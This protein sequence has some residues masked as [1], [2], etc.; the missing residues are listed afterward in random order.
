VLLDAEF[1]AEAFA[2]AVAERPFGI[3]HIASHGEFTADVS[4]SFL[5]AWDQKLSMDR[6]AEIVSTTRFRSEQPLELLALSACETAA[7]DDRAALGLAGVA[8]RAGARSALASLWAVNDEAS[9]ELVS[10][11]YAGLESPGVSRAEALRRAQ[12]Q[13]LADPRMRHAFYW[14]PFLMISNW[15]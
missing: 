15:M 12:V 5:L 14:S 7:G 3:V 10:A 11:F 6:L 2:A 9:A 4:E 1:G 8:L 13:I